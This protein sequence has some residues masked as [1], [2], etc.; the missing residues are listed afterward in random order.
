MSIYK[1]ADDEIV[2][3]QDSHVRDE[4]SGKVTLILTNHSIVQINRGLFG[5]DSDCEVHPLT[6]LRSA[7]GNPNV[8][9]G[10][11]RSGAK[12]LELY[13]NS[14]EKYYV[15]DST[16]AERKWA[17]SI[18]KAYKACIQANKKAQ[19]SH[20]NGSLFTPILGAVDAARKTITPTEKAT[21]TIV[22]KCPYCGAELSGKKG[23][24]I[25][26]SYCD[27]VVHLK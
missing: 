10:K 17:F 15:F 22:G 11:N 18:T 2:I 8:L 27:A 1:L 16:L 21:K 5:N 7:D 23:E 19:K 9:V 12:R 6:D 13:F 26:C 20:Q 4:S 24:D 14:S 3:M 25:Q